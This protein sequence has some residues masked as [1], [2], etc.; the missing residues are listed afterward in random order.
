MSTIEEANVNRQKFMETKGNIL[1]LLDKTIEYYTEEANENPDNKSANDNKVAFE[2]LKA[3]LKRN[4]TQS[5]G[6]DR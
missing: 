6:E 1:S 5:R 3:D 2:K 4:L